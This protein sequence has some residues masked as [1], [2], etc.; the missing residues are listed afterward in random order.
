MR[1]NDVERTLG[2]VWI[3]SFIKA[4]F[5]KISFC[6]L[7]GKPCLFPTANFEIST[8]VYGIHGGLSIMSSH[9]AFQ[10]KKEKVL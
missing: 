4:R 2:L 10:P 9:R 5:L 1:C 3:S 8:S 6:L 7:F